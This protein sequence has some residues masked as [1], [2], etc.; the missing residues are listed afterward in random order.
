MSSSLNWKR[1][2]RK[3]NKPLILRTEKNRKHAP[4]QLSIFLS[5]R[6]W[7]RS[8]LLSFADKSWKSR[9][10]DQQN[11]LYVPQ[12]PKIIDLATNVTKDFGST[13]GRKGKESGGT[14]GR[15]AFRGDTRTQRILRVHKDATHFEGTQWRKVFDNCALCPWERGHEFVCTS[16]G[17][18]FF[19]R[20]INHERKCWGHRGY[21]IRF[22]ALI[23]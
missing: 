13:E 8:D 6:K 15:K 20:A 9:I 17:C 14:H 5:E 22:L 19:F 1:I 23:L 11:T 7:R 4:S 12:G 18:S 10:F 2:I 21:L 16:L 3:P